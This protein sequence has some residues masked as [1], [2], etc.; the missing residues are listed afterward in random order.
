MKVVFSVLQYNVEEMRSTE[1]QDSKNGR[2]DRICGEILK[3]AGEV[4]DFGSIQ[5]LE[6]DLPKVPDEGASNNGDESRNFI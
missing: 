3:T 4:P 2:V 5:E 6:F 1:V